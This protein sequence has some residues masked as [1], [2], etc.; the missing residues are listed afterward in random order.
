LLP[1]ARPK[2][3]QKSADGEDGDALERAQV[4]QVAV[5]ADDQVGSGIQGTGQHPLVGR[6]FGHS[7]RNLGI[8]RYEQGVTLQQGA[9]TCYV[10]VGDGILAPDAGVAQGGLEFGDDGRRANQQIAPIAPGVQSLGWKAL[11]FPS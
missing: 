8:S 11:F 7:A 4:Q 9:Q 1:S 5:A 2:L 6:V 10:L 3:L